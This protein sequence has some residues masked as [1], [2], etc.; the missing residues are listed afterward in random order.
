MKFEIGKRTPDRSEEGGRDFVGM[1]T[2][3]ETCR[4]ATQY[5]DE[6]KLMDKLEYLSS[7]EDDRL[8]IPRC[9]RLA[10]YATPCLSGGHDVFV[11]AVDEMGTRHPILTGK[12]FY[13]FFVAF[14]IAGELARF[15]Y[16]D[17]S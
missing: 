5:L 11:D 15:F 1:A 4:A 10:C 8:E 9:E 14:E 3:G 13:G 6:I 12:T 16:Q 7:P 2:Y 17:N